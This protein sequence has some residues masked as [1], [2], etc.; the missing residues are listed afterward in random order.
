MDIGGETWQPNYVT[1]ENRQYAIQRIR[2]Q[3]NEIQTR[4]VDLQFIAVE[5]ALKKQPEQFAAPSR[6]EVEKKIQDS[7]A[8]AGMPL[9]PYLF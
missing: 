5:A 6:I 8:A 2:E 7:F 9:L 1:T 4:I 3:V